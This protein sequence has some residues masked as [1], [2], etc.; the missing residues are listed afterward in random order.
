MNKLYL[1]PLVIFFISCEKNDSST[2]LTIHFNHTN[3]N[4]NSLEL[5]ST[6]YLNS[7]S[8]SYT[9][10]RLWYLISNLKLHR[11]NGELVDIEDI[12]F[13]DI[14]NRETTVI[15]FGT[16]DEGMYSKV[17]FTFGLD[18]SKNVDNQYVNDSWHS[19][20]FW[21]NNPMMGSGGYHYMKL[22]GTYDTINQF[23][24]CHTGPTM[25]SDYSFNVE[26]PIDFNTNDTEGIM[27]NIIMNV[28]NWFENPNNFVL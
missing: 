28:N 27:L 13:V 16:I 24:N 4:S 1:I 23:Y 22:E 19:D 17:S 2:N 26:L 15:D 10:N 12:H 9:V 14:S 20:M 5:D 3:N 8:Q 21:P 11:S 6:S 25:G 7:S 18:S